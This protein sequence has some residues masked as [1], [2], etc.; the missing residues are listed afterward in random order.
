MFVDYLAKIGIPVLNSWIGKKAHKDVYFG[1]M[2]YM[3]GPSY[4]ASPYSL[5]DLLVVLIVMLKL[6]WPTEI[7]AA[8]WPQYL[9]YYGAMMLP[10]FIPGKRPSWVTSIT[11]LVRWSLTWLLIEY[12]GWQMGAFLTARLTSSLLLVVLMLI[13]KQHPG[14]EDKS[15]PFLSPWY[16]M[17]LWLGLAEH[18]AL[19][20]FLSFDEQIGWSGLV[21]YSMK[22]CNISFP[23]PF[24]L[25]TFF[26]RCRAGHLF[27][28]IGAAFGRCFEG[29][30]GCRLDCRLALLLCSIDAYL[31]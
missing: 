3:E 24:C 16:G 8:Q 7:S 21:F 14:G 13:A 2:L 25:T 20:Y 17:P 18:I 9:L 1:H 29:S 19:R 30:A 26:R 4:L 12:G 22:T 27:E 28:S 6:T 10:C 15:K 23:R 11:D 5:Y 31:F